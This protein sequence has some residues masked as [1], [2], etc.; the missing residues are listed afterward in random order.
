MKNV[1]SGEILDLLLDNIL[2]KA[3]PQ[4]LG[5]VQIGDF[6]D[7][8]DFYLYAAL[9]ELRLRRIVSPMAKTDAVADLVMSKMA[10]Q[11]CSDIIL[12]HVD[13]E[14]DKKDAAGY[15]LTQKGLIELLHLIIHT[16]RNEIGGHEFTGV[17]LPSAVCVKCT[18]QA[19]GATNPLDAIYCMHCGQKLEV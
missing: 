8:E 16:L 10:K 13:K 15:L 2:K 5:L 11:I 12:S 6:E 7:C 3:K 17:A 9:T 18:N 1:I 4:T 14:L 19:C